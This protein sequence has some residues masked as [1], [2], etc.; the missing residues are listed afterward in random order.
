MEGKISAFIC[1]NS[2][3]LPLCTILSPN[4]LSLQR[5][6]QISVLFPP[7][8]TSSKFLWQWQKPDLRLQGLTACSTPAEC[9]YFSDDTVFIP[10]LNQ[11]RVSGQ[12][13]AMIRLCGSTSKV[14]C[15]QQSFWCFSEKKGH[16]ILYLGK[17]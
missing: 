14:F 7:V 8:V 16:K 12:R 11:S 2:E 6:I 15:K 3:L 10:Q 1:L 17:S 4:L 9:K 5:E 13:K